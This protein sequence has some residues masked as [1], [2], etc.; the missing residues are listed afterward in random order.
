MVLYFFCLEQ[1]H[2]R[3]VV[4]HDCLDHNHEANGRQQLTSDKDE[5]VNRGYPVRVERHDPVNH[6]EANRERVQN[7][8]RRSY[9]AEAR[10]Q[11]FDRRIILLGRLAQQRP[12]DHDPYCEINDRTTDV[13]VQEEKSRCASP[14]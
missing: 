14:L 13:A 11:V 8:A 4:G 12:S 3:L 6:G 2:H 10:T 1:R 9:A 5:A 7:E